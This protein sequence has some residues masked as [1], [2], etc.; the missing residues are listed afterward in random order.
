MPNS[1][2]YLRPG[3]QHS[4]SH[5]LH[6]N[7]SRK[8]LQVAVYLG[9]A[10][11]LS[12]GNKINRMSPHG[13]KNDWEFRESLQKKERW[14]VGKETK[15]LRMEQTQ[16]TGYKDTSRVDKAKLQTNETE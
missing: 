15:S 13:S 6:T 5:F 12:D 2:L 11:Q 14:G 9:R 8:Y 4:E 10:K 7:Y 1:T 16:R 3:P